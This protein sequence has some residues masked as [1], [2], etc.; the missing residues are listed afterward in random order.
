LPPRGESDTITALRQN[1]RLFG[2]N[3]RP[4]ATL[5]AAVLAAVLN[6][7][8]WT[9]VVLYSQNTLYLNGRWLATKRSL[10]MS[11]VGADSFLITRAALS[12]DRLDLGSWYGRHE[13]IFRTPFTPREISLRFSAGEL[14]VL[15]D[16]T[17]AG[18]SGVR[19]ADGRAA[20]FRADAVGRFLETVPL[21][22]VVDGSWHRLRLAFGGGR[23]SVELDGR[24]IG[25]VPETPVAGRFGL[26]A[27]MSRALVS[28]VRLAADDGAVYAESFANFK[29]GLRL[30]LL[31]FVLAL[32]AALAGLRLL[33]RAGLSVRRARL[34]LLAA[35]GG[36]AL[37]GLIFLSFDYYDWSGRELDARSRPM[38]DAAAARSPALRIEAAR[39]RVF[40]WWSALAGT[41]A[42]TPEG[43]ARQGYPRDQIWAG[44]LF[45]ARD[46]SVVRKGAE[47]RVARA[48]SALRVL[49][50]GSSQTI[51]AGAESA[52]STFV[53]RTH[54]LMIAA[55]GPSRPLE[56]LNI[57]VSG[58]VGPRLLDDDRDKYLAFRP[59][60]MVID[61]ASNDDAQSLRASVE[62]FLA[63]NASLG[64][65][66]IL[67]K[68]AVACPDCPEQARKHAVLDELA[69]RYRAPIYDLHGYLAGPAV[70]SS[71]YLWWDSDHLAPYGHELVAR[72]LAPKV[73]ENL[74]AARRA[75]PTRARARRSSPPRSAPR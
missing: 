47:R 68:E 22:A 25:A 54:R 32:L 31:D 62:G 55:L 51:G 10:E 9:E 38:G 7:F 19:F 39:V 75:G 1:F 56:S 66:T 36:A 69:R 71:G 33:A 11:L 29:N 23:M 70:S 44:P 26:R 28:D 67:L 17:A 43:L 6:A 2:P 61:L 15:F 58:S 4:G 64:V 48:D 49:Y 74:L 65:K 46:G 45:F 8:V 20:F 41:P 16:K 72:W 59:D 52:E 14:A 63:L 21:D 18:F 5:L 53:G 12:R 42:V 30:L 35:G 3:G 40:G 57:A 37:A 24:E 50:V 34:A 60:L 13:L 27:G 73:L